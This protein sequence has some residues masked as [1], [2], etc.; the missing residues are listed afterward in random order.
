MHH[1][2]V[3]N[4]EPLTVKVTSGRGSYGRT[5][6]ATVTF[7]AVPGLTAQWLQRVVD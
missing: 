2:D 7:R 4:V 6:G 3:A 1:E 5:V